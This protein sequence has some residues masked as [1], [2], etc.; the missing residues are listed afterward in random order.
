MRFGNLKIFVMMAALTAMPTELLGQSDTTVASSAT[1]AG[2]QSSLRPGDLIRL[3]I[4]REP[5]I[6]GDFP[7]DELG[8]VNFPLVGTM[9]VVT[10]SRETVHQRL[11]EAYKRSIENLSMDVI[12]LRRV[13]V[14]GAVRTPGLYPIDPTM[15]VG[16]ALAL[17]GGPTGDASDIHIR[18][19]RSGNVVIDNI[20]AARLVSDLPI[21]RGDQIH[22]PQG[23]LARNPWIFGTLIQSLVTLTATIVTLSHR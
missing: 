2:T 21:Q 3:R 9:S 7:V 13:A 23:F 10:V 17:A 1:G 11:L 19:V 8:R 5:E 20:D 6:S 12:F 16:D 14:V 15:T 18:L 22:I 4:W